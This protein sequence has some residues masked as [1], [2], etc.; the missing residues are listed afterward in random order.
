M[1]TN[2]QAARSAHILVVGSQRAATGLGRRR[3][4]LACLLILAL[5]ALAYVRQ[6][7][8]VAAAGYDVQELQMVRQRRLAAVEQLRFQLAKMRALDRVAREAERRGLA[9]AEQVV[10]VRIAAQPQPA[11]A[12][13]ATPPDDLRQLVRP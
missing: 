4:L 11:A 2:G 7:S 1:R 12:P 9:P 6:A 13:P 5:A 8:L 10:Y 3:L